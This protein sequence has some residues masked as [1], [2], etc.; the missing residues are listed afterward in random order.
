MDEFARTSVYASASRMHLTGR[1][2]ID[3]SEQHERLRSVAP[4][5]RST[6]RAAAE[7]CDVLP[8]TLF[9]DVRDG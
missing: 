8:T 3:R 7:A 9:R 2:N 4:E 5:Q 6:I 1:K